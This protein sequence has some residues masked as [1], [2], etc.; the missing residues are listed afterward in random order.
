MS[1]EL[2]R[3]VAVAAV[4]IPVAL[5][6]IWTGG[7][8]LA[9]FLAVIAAG[10]AM[11]FYRLAAH[12]GVR[13]FAEAG[14]LLAALPVLAAGFHVSTVFAATTSWLIFVAGTLLIFAAAIFRRGPD[15]GPMAATA[16]TVTGAMFTGGTLAHAVLLRGMWIPARGAEPLPVEGLLVP[17][18]AWLGPALLLFPLIL[19]WTS[20]TA[21]YFAGR[22]YGRRKLIPAV[23]PGKT[24]EGAVAGVLGTAVVGALYGHF[25]FHQALVLPLGLGF[26]LLAGLIISPVAQI[27]DLAES[28]LKREA[29]VKDSGTLL[30]GHGGLL[31]RFDSLF[32][33]IPAMYWLLEVALQFT[34]RVAI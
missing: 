5:L 24:V 27:G 25:I 6:V 20:D 14:A 13:P 9:V 33:T 22:R 18:A 26:G 32:F 15:G 34:D 8:L 12:R 10:A 4:G 1:S 17:A 19:T 11:E 2:A 28:L 31:D 30:P 3:R 16:V 23:S 21:A 7:T 29:G